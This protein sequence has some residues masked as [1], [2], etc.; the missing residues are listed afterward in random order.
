MAIEIVHF[1][2]KNGGS[3][4]CY[5]SSPEGS[6]KKQNHLKNVY[7]FSLTYY[8]LRLELSGVD[9]VDLRYLWA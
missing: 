7:R 2:I 5:V 3:F 8:D 6:Y 9:G 1:T 4:H